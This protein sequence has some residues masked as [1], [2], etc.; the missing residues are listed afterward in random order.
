M[1]EQRGI[2]RNYNKAETLGYIE[3]ESGA[4]ILF[5]RG[6][7]CE[8]NLLDEGRRVTFRFHQF[9]QIAVLISL[10]D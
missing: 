3:N 8:S 9:L 4:C 1:I 7:I 2:V 5:F 6:S 10:I